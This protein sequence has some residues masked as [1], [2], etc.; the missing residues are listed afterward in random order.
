MPS[1]E[2][3]Q[4]SSPINTTIKKISYT[5]KVSYWSE[6]DY[7]TLNLLSIVLE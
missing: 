5:F 4:H 6:R 2:I 1:I 7:G 3:H